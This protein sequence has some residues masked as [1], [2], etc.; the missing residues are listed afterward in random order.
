MMV[1]VNTKKHPMQPAAA[2]VRATAA[3]RRRS[4]RKGLNKLTDKQCRLVLELVASSNPGLTF[5]L[6]E[7]YRTCA[8]FKKGRNVTVACSTA[9]KKLSVDPSTLRAIKSW[10]QHDEIED[11]DNWMTRDYMNDKLFE[12][13]SWAGLLSHTFALPQTVIGMDSYRINHV[14]PKN[15]RWNGA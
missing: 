11:R 7:H 4:T 9:G 10:R 2:T 14:Q 13:H 5:N 3:N 1:W 6:S 15:A 12:E 8:D